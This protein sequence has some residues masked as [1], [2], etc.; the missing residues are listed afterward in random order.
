M[1]GEGGQVDEE[2]NVEGLKALKKIFEVSSQTP[3]HTC[4]GSFNVAQ[5]CV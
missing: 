1:A 5:P 3:A 2:I 4:R